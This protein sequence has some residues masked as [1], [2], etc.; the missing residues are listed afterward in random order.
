MPM[1]VTKIKIQGLA[2]GVGLLGAGLV[3]T[4]LYFLLKKT[5][6]CTPCTPCNCYAE[7]VGPWL[8]ATT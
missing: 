7:A 6:S 2:T 4:L 5:P 8:P 3:A 1:R